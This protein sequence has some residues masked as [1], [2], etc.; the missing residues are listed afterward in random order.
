[1]TESDKV[2]SVWCRRFRAVVVFCLCDTY[3]SNNNEINTET[4]A[5]HIQ[6]AGFLFPI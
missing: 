2:V 6:D 5:V 4:P 1:M 3:A